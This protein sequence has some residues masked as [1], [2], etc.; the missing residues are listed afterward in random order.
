MTTVQMKNLSLSLVLA[1]C[2]AACGSEPPPQDKLTLENGVDSAVQ[3]ERM[4]ED[5]EHLLQH[6]F[7]HGDRGSSEKAGA[8]YNK[9]I[10]NDV[11]NVDKYTSAGQQALNLGIYGADLSYTSVFNHTQEACSTPL[12]HANL[13]IGWALSAL[14]MTAHW[15]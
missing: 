5:Q 10:L 8:K 7:A 12:V 2:L 4:K 1:A 3:A 14:S 15:S 9:N 11:K 6:S 13:P